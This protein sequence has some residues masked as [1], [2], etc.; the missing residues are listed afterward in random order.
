[1]CPFKAHTSSSMELDTNHT[2]QTLKILKRKKEKDSFKRKKQKAKTI[3][4][5]LTMLVIR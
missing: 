4:T 5:F 3:W 2:H 1:M